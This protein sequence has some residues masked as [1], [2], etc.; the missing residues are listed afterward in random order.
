MNNLHNYI[1]TV[2]GGWKPN[3]GR[4]LSLR[5]DEAMSL[6]TNLTVLLLMLLPLSGYSNPAAE[7]SLSFASL[8]MAW[9]LEQERV[10]RPYIEEE[11]K[12]LQQIAL[13]YQ[14][15]HNSGSLAT[16]QSYIYLLEQQN[17]AYAQLLN[18]RKEKEVSL[19]KV[20]YLKGIS[21][22]K[23]IYEKLLSLDHHFAGLQT[24]QN[25]SILS[26]P[27]SYPEFRKIN[28]V[29]EEKTDKKFAF[30]MPALLQSNPFLTA[31]YSM[32]ST[33]L[34][35]GKSTEKEAD[36]EKIA[37]ILD[38]TV[39][40]N[41]DLK[42]IRHETDYL[43]TANESLKE[44]CERLFEEYTK[45]LGYYV[46][47]DQC[48]KND[49]WESLAKKLQDYIGQLEGEIAPNTPPSED[50][51]RMQIEIVFA[52]ER[53]A[54]FVSM[55]SNFINQGIQYYQKFDN[56]VS[57]YENEDFCETQLPTQF[58]ELKHDIK[59]TIEKYKN[60]YNLPEIHGSRLKY[61][62]YGSPDY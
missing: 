57:S 16:P 11:E 45:F 54:D 7:D 15:Q 9:E 43:Q 61:L 5:F 53:V 10:L 60:T 49:D 37:C 48:R 25:I 46:P 33:M 3:K 51:A 44:E 39:R 13:L 32:V 34:G 24:V 30:Q 12:T 23:L 31:T 35:S 4:F 29:I 18:I 26:N 41:G 2:I 50:M 62:L 28:S 47:L 1:F 38:F 58:E 56:I 8:R 6:I 55:Y 52:T 59:T 19:L 40:M 14:L 22:I 17:N 27:H 21:L 20:R 36:F 42:T